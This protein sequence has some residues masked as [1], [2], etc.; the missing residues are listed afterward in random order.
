MN[1]ATHN[2]LLRKLVNSRWGDSITIRASA[3]TLHCSVGNI[4]TCTLPGPD[5]DTAC[6]AITGCLKTTNVE[7]LYMLVRIAPCYIRRDGCARIL[8]KKLMQH[9]TCMVKCRLSNTWK[10]IRCLFRGI[11]ASTVHHARIPSLYYYI[12]CLRD[13]KLYQFLLLTHHYQ[14]HRKLHQRPQSIHHIQKQNIST[15]LIQ[16]GVLSHTLFNIYT[17]DTP[18]PQVPVK[19][20]TYADYITIT[21]T[22]NDINIAKSNHIYMK[23]IHGLGQTTSSSTQTRQHALSSHQTQQNI[24]HNL[25]YK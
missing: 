11:N 5:L 2:N 20:T 25:N 3:L 24:A 18:T 22:H 15:T 8:M 6:R 14:I 12:L 17:S 23:Y 16:G 4:V 13:T 1:V 19:P 21:S 7:D 10:S 9:I